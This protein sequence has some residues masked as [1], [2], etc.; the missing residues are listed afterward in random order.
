MSLNHPVP[1]FTGNQSYALHRSSIHIQWNTDNYVENLL[2]GWGESFVT[3][4]SSRPLF[5]WSL[6]GVEK[7]EPLTAL[8]FHLPGPTADHLWHSHPWAVFD[9]V[10]VELTGSFSG[11]AFCHIC[12]SWGWVM[13]TDHCGSEFSIWSGKWSFII[14]FWNHQAL[15]SPNS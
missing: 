11:Q 12:S 4:I 3:I 13:G 5:L 1:L 15:F 14:L 7:E 10:T 6:R 8:P 2:P 9:E